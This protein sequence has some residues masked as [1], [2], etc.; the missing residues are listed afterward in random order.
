M[1]FLVDKKF[2][3]S[4]LIKMHSASFLTKHVQMINGLYLSDTLLVLS[5]T[6]TTTYT[7]SHIHPFRNTYSS[8]IHRAFSVQCLAQ[9]IRG[10]MHIP[11]HVLYILRS[12]NTTF[13]FWTICLLTVT[14][15][16]TLLSAMLAHIV[17][18]II[19]CWESYTSLSLL[20]HCC[21]C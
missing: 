4:F 9:I 16:L 14:L 19:I 17:Q 18:I 12:G 11:A 3:F 15:F 20:T 10:V 8:S 5:T 1:E 6:Y 7:T 13:V 21:G 2:T